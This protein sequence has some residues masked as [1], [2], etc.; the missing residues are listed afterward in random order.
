MTPDSPPSD[1]DRRTRGSGP[2]ARGLGWVTVLALAI[3]AASSV[4]RSPLAAGLYAV[5]GLAMGVLV[6]GWQAGATS[7]A[8]SGRYT[9]D[10]FSGS[11]S[12]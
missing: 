4:A 6:S 9:R 2:I 5:A 7:T 10:R 8:G 11:S 3:V 1:T 12:Y